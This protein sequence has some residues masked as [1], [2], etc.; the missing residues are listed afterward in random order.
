M[1]LNI[2]YSTEKNLGQQNFH[3]S[4][5]TY[6]AMVGAFGS[7][8]TATGCVEGLILSL[9]YPGNIGLIARATFPD[10]KKTTYQR[11]LDI[12][13]EP[14]ILEHNKT[15]AMLKLKTN[16]KPSTIFFG[17]LD[18]L[19]RY[20]S[21]ELGWYFIDE[22]DETSEEHWLILA[23]RLRLKDKRLCGMLATNPTN[24][25]HWI[26]KRFVK[27]IRSGY[28]LF[29]SK[30]K[31]NIDH[32]PPEYYSNLIENM[33][34]D[35]VKRYVDGEWGSLQ[36]GNPVYPDFNVSVHV[37]KVE[38]EMGA[39]VNRGWDFGYHRPFCCWTEFA[40]NGQFRILYSMLGEDEDLEPFC[41]RALR[42]SEELFPGSTFADYCDPAG[43]QKKDDGRPSIGVLQGRGIF[44]RFRQSKPEKRAMAMRQLMRTRIDGKTESFLIV[45]GAGSNDYLIEGFISGIV[46]D[47][48]RDGQAKEEIL[49]DGYYDHG[50]DGVGYVIANTC[51]VRSGLVRSAQDFEI[52][53]P[54]WS[55]GGG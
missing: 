20:K 13:P 54:K 14:L 49:K 40:Q 48:L 55:Y 32:L 22:A 17:P 37:K 2:D 36:A 39:T 15:D 21:L 41:D 1:I 6:K 12:C 8:K 38:H 19:G 34:E 27:E 4:T 52:E 50:N 10:L 47:K 23:G 18:K 28:A 29:R 45:P 9:N 31:D 46:Y 11:F 44:P 35:W 53:E 30:T 7:G 3:Q 33:P 26:Y 43:V 16:G 24:T 51:M 5:A 42:K 25:H